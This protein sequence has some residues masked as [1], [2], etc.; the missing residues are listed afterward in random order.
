[1]RVWFLLASLILAG[2]SS[3]A[4]PPSGRLSDSI[5]VVA[6]LNEQLRQWYGTRIAMAG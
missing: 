4:P 2:C 6:Q 5:V 1:M 3:H